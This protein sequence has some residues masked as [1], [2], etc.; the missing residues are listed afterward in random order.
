M[1]APQNSAFVDPAFVDELV[2]D[3]TKAADFVLELMES[4]EFLL[5]VLPDPFNPLKGAPLAV[6]RDPSGSVTIG[7]ALVV[8]PDRQASNGII[9]GVNALP[10]PST[11]P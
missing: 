3:S 2:N 1:V 6:V 9:Q 7:G 5:A 10:V 11:T 8:D 4:T